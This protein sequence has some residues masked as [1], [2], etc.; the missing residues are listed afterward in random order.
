MCTAVSGAP[1]GM[2]P[3]FRSAPQVVHTVVPEQAVVPIC[4]PEQCMLVLS[5]AGTWRSDWRHVLASMANTKHTALVGRCSSPPIAWC[6]CCADFCFQHWFAAA[7]LPQPPHFA[8]AT[9]ATAAAATPAAV[10]QTRRVRK[11]ES[12]G[13]DLA[14]A[15]SVAA[16]HSYCATTAAAT[17]AAAAL[18]S[19]SRKRGKNYLNYKYEARKSRSTVNN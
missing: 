9:S 8:V 3:M 2:G 11:R 5:V 13:S 15:L 10:R 1:S 12:A 16:L 7:A 14:A 19:S 18:Y 17:A 6:G 4:V